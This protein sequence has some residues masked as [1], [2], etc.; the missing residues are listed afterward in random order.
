MSALQPPAPHPSSLPT[1][2]VTA[3]REPHSAR[4][5]WASRTRGLLSKCRGR[6]SQVQSGLQ[7][8]RAS[9]PGLASDH[10]EPGCASA[11]KHSASGGGGGHVKMPQTQ[12]LSLRRSHFF[13]E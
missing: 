12:L 2:C 4:G 9:I 8:G 3:T 6:D 5:R 10:L 13:L 1:D 7:G 11:R